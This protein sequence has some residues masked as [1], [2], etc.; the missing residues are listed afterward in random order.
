MKQF[1]GEV[2]TQVKIH[3]VEGHLVATAG[4]C[5]ISSEVLSHPTTIKS[6]SVKN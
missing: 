3:R 4:T 1:W 5:T 2:V 6:D